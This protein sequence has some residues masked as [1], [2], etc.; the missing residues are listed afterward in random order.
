MKQHGDLMHGDISSKKVMK[1]DSHKRKWRA[2]FLSETK[3]G[4]HIQKHIRIISHQ[5]A[6]LNHKDDIWHK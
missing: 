3:L 4:R 5:D 2:G 1:K 6:I